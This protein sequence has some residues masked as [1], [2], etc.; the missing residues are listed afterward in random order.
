MGR[1]LRLLFLSDTHLGFDEP[2][3]PRSRRPHRGADFFATYH[4]ALDV[5]R[6]ERVDA[7]IHGGDLLYRSRVPDSLVD[8]VMAPLV[9]LA[10][11]GIPVFVVP[12]N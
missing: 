3:R 6:V 7:V 12:G 10:E 11:A 2:L 8:R 4:R 9:E 1:P 5:A